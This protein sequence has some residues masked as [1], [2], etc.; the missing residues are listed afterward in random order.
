MEVQSGCAHILVVEDEPAIRDLIEIQL[1][2]LGYKVTLAANGGEALLALEERGLKPD[3]LITD[4]VMPGM[5]GVV[6]LKRLRKT[7]PALKVLF[8]SGYTDNVIVHQG[9][10]DPGN[11]FIQKPFSVKGL[12]AI[13]CKVLQSSK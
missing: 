11:P 2:N 7:H 10:L 8:M 6:L 4:V 9:I 12:S 3:M 5:S 1:E 13:V